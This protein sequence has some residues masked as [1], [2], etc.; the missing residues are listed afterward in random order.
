MN[1]DL[2]FNGQLTEADFVAAA[3]LSTGGLK[4]KFFIAGCA[5]IYPAW[6]AYSDPYVTDPFNFIFTVIL[7]CV[8]IFFGP[9]YLHQR[10]F[11]KQKSLSFPFSME[12]GDVGLCVKN[13]LGEEVIP[14]S[15]VRRWSHDKTSVIIFPPEGVIKVI[16]RRLF[17]SESEYHSL[18][19][20]L[21]GKLGKAK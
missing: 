20:T 16:P 12:I 18:L 14:W 7:A 9:R 3:N 11:R 15:S 19:E 21:S 2:V 13:E 5:L 6:R 4:R 10:T 8:A 1:S 17:A